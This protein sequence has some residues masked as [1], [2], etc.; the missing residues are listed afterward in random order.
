MK[1]SKRLLSIIPHIQ[2]EDSIIDVGCD[3]AYLDIYLAQHKNL[4]KII[5]VDIMEGPLLI[6]KKNIKTNDLENVIKVV[7]SDG[8]EKLTKDINTVIITGLGGK[9]ITNILKKDESRLININKIVIIPNNNFYET[10]KE[11]TKLGY[12]IEY[13]ELIDDKNIYLL[14]IFKKGNKRYSYKELFF[15]PFLLKEKNNLFKKYYLAEVTKI[16]EI[17][18]KLPKRYIIKHIRMRQKIRTIKQILK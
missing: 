15:G 6:A 9:T 17:L 3:H 10:R 13:E 8:L 4:K 1:L 5:A 7:R 18:T 2:D 14:I 12:K 16:K 11:I